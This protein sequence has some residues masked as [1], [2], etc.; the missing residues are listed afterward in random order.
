MLIYLYLYHRKNINSERD[1][2][3]NISALLRKRVG[4]IQK[5]VVSIQTIRNNN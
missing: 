2:Y 4:F 3:G 5:T 1:N